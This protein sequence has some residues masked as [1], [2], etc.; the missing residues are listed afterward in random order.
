MTCRPDE[1]DVEVLDDAHDA[2]RL[3]GAPVGRHRHEVEL[4]REVDAPGEV[5]HEHDRT[6]QHADQQ[7]AAP[8]VVRGD[9]GAELRD[10][11]LQA[12]VADDQLPERRVVIGMGDDGGVGRGHE[13]RT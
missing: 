3:R 9:L 8:G 11:L 2:A 10:A 6:L 5:G 12:V 13:R 1:V 7:R 4:D